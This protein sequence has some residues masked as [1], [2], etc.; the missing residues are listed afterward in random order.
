[1]IKYN[2]QSHLFL[3]SLTSFL[4]YEIREKRNMLVIYRIE[5]GMFIELINNDLLWLNRK[6][7]KAKMIK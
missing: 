7:E 3:S 5:C 6:K 1:M 2:N 4:D